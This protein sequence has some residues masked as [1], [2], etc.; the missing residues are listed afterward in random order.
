M[1]DFL[2]RLYALMAPMWTV[3]LAGAWAAAIVLL[4]RLILKNRVPRQ[5]LCLLWLVVFARLALPFSFQSPVSLVPSP[6]TEDIPAR[7]EQFT[8]RIDPL[9]QG[10]QTGLTPD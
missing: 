4:L 5:V 8:G 7:V 9:P 10:G 3:S 6:V 2:N 1:I